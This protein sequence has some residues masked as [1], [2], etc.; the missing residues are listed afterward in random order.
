MPAAVSAARDEE[1]AFPSPA[2]KAA[3][4]CPASTEKIRGMGRQRA[5]TKQPSTL[6]ALTRTSGCL[7]LP[8]AFHA[9]GGGQLVVIDQGL[10][11]TIRISVQRIFSNQPMFGEIVALDALP[12]I[13]HLPVAVGVIG[14]LVAE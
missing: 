6:G 5:P 8:E 9:H 14:K 7:A 4:G 3:T 2:V 12:V 10:D 13:G 1:F 11:G